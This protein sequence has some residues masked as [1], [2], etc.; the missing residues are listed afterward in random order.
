MISSPENGYADFQSDDSKLELVDIVISSEEAQFKITT[1]KHEKFLSVAQSICE[2]KGWKLTKTRF[3][4]DG[5]RLQNDLTFEENEVQNHS[6][7]SVM[8]EMVGGKGPTDLEIL[9]MLEEAP[10]E[11]EESEEIECTEQAEEANLAE[12]E[13]SHTVSN[14]KLY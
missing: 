6:V 11:D 3:I 14:Y 8:F 7:I 5:E 10:S 9:K 13:C 2:L 12:V 1:S 4:L